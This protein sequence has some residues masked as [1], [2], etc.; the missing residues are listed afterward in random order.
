[1]TH[2]EPKSEHTTSPPG[3]TDISD[4]EPLMILAEVS[5]Q[6]EA[7]QEEAPPESRGDFKAPEE[8]QEKAPA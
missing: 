3:P 1:M 2:T 6:R 5:F 7:A 4:E 8:L